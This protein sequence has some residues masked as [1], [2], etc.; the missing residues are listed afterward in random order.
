MSVTKTNSKVHFTSLANK[1]ISILAIL[2]SA[3]TL[4]GGGRE[5]LNRLRLTTTK[6]IPYGK[7]H[8][9]S[10]IKSVSAEFTALSEFFFNQIPFRLQNS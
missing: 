5:V 3:R 8:L 4:G 7:K 10:E 9:S 6:K 2:F 1:L